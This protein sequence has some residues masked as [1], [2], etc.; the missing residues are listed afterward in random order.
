MDYRISDPRIAELLKNKK[1]K[2]NTESSSLD[3]KSQDTDSEIK[4][5]NKISENDIAVSYTHLT[6]PTK[7]SV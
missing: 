7:C 5:T 2:L 3:L 4:N 6:L 1:K